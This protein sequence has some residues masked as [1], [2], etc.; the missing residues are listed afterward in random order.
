MAGSG[1]PAGE[2]GQL[3]G[4]FRD[5]LSGERG[6][7]PGTVDNY[8][9]VAG[10]FVGQLADPL[11]DALRGLSA[12]RVLATIGVLVRPGGPSVRSLAVGLRG[13]LRFL[14]VTGQVPRSLVEAVPSEPRWRLASLPAGLDG[15]AVTALLQTCDRDTERGRRDYAI[16]LLL[17]RLGLRAAEVTGLVL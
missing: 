10:L 11:D 16:L 14:F 7:V 9:H 6:L 4:S 15:S 8:A 2:R 5:Y 1:F 3:V 13:L 17:A 12:G